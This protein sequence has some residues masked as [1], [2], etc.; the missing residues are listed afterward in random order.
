MIDDSLRQACNHALL[1]KDQE[2]HLLRKI[3]AGC[4]DSRN[5][6]IAHN[7]RLVLF[8]ALKRTGQGLPLDDLFQIGIEGLINSIKKFDISRG[9]R[10]SSYAIYHIRREI[11][12]AIVSNAR[13]RAWHTRY[14][15]TTFEDLKA[16]RLEDELGRRFNVEALN[17]AIG[18]LTS[19]QLTILRLFYGLGNKR[20]S[21]AEIAEIVALTTD[22]IKYHLINSRR[23][24]KEVLSE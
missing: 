6:L 21:Y 5:E 14:E 1:S 4:Q 23:I 18:Q 9:T 20:H 24:L 2:A 3:L 12:N 17:K 13:G 7:C 22:S 16:H 11:N 19:Q 10:L 15:Q 8:L